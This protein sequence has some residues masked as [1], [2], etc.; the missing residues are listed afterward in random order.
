MKAVA[1][2]VSEK[3][4]TLLLP[5][6]DLDDSGLYEIAEPRVI[7]ALETYTPSCKYKPRT[8]VVL[9]LLLETPITNAS[10]YRAPN[11]AT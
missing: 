5:A 6:V 9:D 1:S 4:D 10:M 7:T 8:P 11:S 3:N 2:K